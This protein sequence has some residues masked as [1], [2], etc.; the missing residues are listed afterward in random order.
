MSFVVKLKSQVMKN[1][2]SIGDGD[3][4]YE[5]N[6]EVIP[7]ILLYYLYTFLNV[8]WRGLSDV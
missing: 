2:L 3:E 1:V 4:L 7:N 8:T 6:S 5:K